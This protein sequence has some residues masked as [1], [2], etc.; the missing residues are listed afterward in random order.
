L[1]PTLPAAASG[2][3]IGREGGREPGGQFLARLPA[4]HITHPGRSNMREREPAAKVEKRSEKAT[5]AGGK[6]KSRMPSKEQPPPCHPHHF[7]LQKRAKRR[8]IHFQ[9][10]LI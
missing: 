3:H 2:V 9:L 6:E 8:S 5:P 7:M 4:V 1:L 10:F